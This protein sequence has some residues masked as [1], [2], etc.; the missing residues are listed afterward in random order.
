MYVEELAEVVAIDAKSAKRF[1]PDRRF[2]KPQDIISL[3][4]SLLV[5]TVESDPDSDDQVA[6][7]QQIRLAHF[8]VKEYLLSQHMLSERHMPMRP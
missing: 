4:P 8:S 2:P 5:A 7:Q 1:D 6:R 3:C